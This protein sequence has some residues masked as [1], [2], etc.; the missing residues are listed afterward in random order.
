[1]KGRVEEASAAERVL[2]S[3]PAQQMVTDSRGAGLAPG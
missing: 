2:Y 3:G 1:M